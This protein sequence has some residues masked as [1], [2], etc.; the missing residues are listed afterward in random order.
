M[1]YLFTISLLV[2][3][4]NCKKEVVGTID[5]EKDYF[6]LEINFWQEYKVDSITFSDFTNP[7]TIDT[8]SYFLKELI[9]SD[10]LD[11]SNNTNYRVEQYKRYENSSW[12]INNIFSQ[13]ATNI[14][15]QKVE[16]DLRFIKLVFPP[17]LNKT[18]NGHIYIDVIDEPSLDFYNPTKFEWEYTFTAIDEK[19]EIGEFTFD[20]CVTVIQ[21][22]EENLF[23][24]KYSK[25]IYAKNVG[26]VY[27]ELMILETQAAPSNAPFVERAENGFILKYTITDYKH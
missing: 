9:E 11:L 1:R 20:S 17:E 7:V 10:Y 8:S 14:N 13:K 25:E 12:F 3:L 16:N 2:F 19:L 26:L 4:L 18:W 22:D 5:L 21:I 23:E 15:F 6:P 27:K 24:K